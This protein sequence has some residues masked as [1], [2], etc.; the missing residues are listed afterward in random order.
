MSGLHLV[1]WNVLH[2]IH[3][4]KWSKHVVGRFPREAVRIERITE[5]VAGWL[6]AGVSAVCLQEV[7]GDQLAALRRVKASLFSHRYPRVPGSI[8]LLWSRPLEDRSEHLATLVAGG[9]ARVAEALTYRSDSGKGLLAVDLADGL[10]LV[11]THLSF[12]KDGIGQL[13]QAAGVMRQV[14]RGALAGDLNAGR[15]VIAALLGEGVALSQVGAATCSPSRR[16]GPGKAIDHVAVHGGGL[17]GVEVLD[18]EG[19]SDHQPVRAVLR[20]S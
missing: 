15:D 7:S 6:A 19:L 8:R 5:R 12:G 1:T 18:G 17:D 14:A 3:G 2:R 11:N 13:Q 4:E 20:F 9:G 16:H 10:R